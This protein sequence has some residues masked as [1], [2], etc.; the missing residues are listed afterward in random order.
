MVSIVSFEQLNVPYGYK[1][2][3]TGAI[4]CWKCV[5]L[6]L[7]RR[8]ER[9]RGKVHIFRYEKHMSDYWWAV[10]SMFKGQYIIIVRNEV[11]F[12]V[13]I[14]QTYNR[15]REYKTEDMFSALRKQNLIDVTMILLMV[16]LFNERRNVECYVSSWKGHLYQSKDFMYFYENIH[17]Y[18]RKL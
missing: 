12:L 3:L 2:H 10:I 15:Q 17:L 13:Q 14:Y 11:T 7:R 18:K 8:Q 5:Q 1:L 6:N 4:I 9:E 16:A